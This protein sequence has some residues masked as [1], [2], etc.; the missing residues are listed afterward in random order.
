MQTSLQLNKLFDNGKLVY[1]Y[2]TP[3]SGST[4]QRLH[5][6]AFPLYS[7]CHTPTYFDQ[8]YFDPFAAK[9]YGYHSRAGSPLH[10][11]QCQGSQ[12][13]RHYPRSKHPAQSQQ[14][15]YSPQ[16]QSPS[17]TTAVQWCAVIRT[18]HHMAWQT[19]IGWSV[20]SRALGEI[21]SG[22]EVRATPTLRCLA[23]ARS[24]TRIR[25]IHALRTARILQRS[26]EIGHHY[27]VVELCAVQAKYARGRKEGATCDRSERERLAVRK[28][29]QDF[30]TRKSRLAFFSFPPQVLAREDIS[31]R[32][33]L[34]TR[35]L[36][37]PKRRCRRTPSGSDWRTRVSLVVAISIMLWIEFEQDLQDEICI[38]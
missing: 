30:P 2:N 36:I 38:W 9:V 23:T 27:T 7:L 8:C 28:F 35:E 6:P 13:Q 15:R 33:A 25:A 32:H 16:S 11:A 34:D 3:Y 37:P 22:S 21:P 19:L 12:E 4:H 24:S 17:F 18:S 1:P 10:A 29:S 20:S 26:F 14:I 5:E 31:C